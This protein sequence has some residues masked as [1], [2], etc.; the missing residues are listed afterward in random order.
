MLTTVW[1]PPHCPWMYMYICVRDSKRIVCV[2]VRA[3]QCSAV[4]CS[5][6]IQVQYVGPR[7]WCKILVWL[8]TLVAV[9]TAALDYLTFTTSVINGR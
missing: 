8:T 1:Q 3:L 7:S 4:Q 2:S 5:V 6:D 9:V